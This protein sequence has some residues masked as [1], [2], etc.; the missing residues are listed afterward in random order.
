MRAIDKTAAYHQKYDLRFL[1]KIMASKEGTI[2]GTLGDFFYGPKVREMFNDVL[3][4]PVMV[5]NRIIEQGKTVQTPA[6][7]DFKGAS[8]TFRGVP[9]VFVSNR[10]MN[11][12]IKALVEEAVHI[13]QGKTGEMEVQK[14]TDWNAPDWYEK[15][16]RLPQEVAA[17][18]AFNEALELKEEEKVNFDDPSTWKYDTRKGYEKSAQ[19]KLKKPW[20]MTEEEFQSG[21]MYPEEATNL[22]RSIRMGIPE[23]KWKGGYEDYKELQVP[24]KM[25]TV[26]V[27]LSIFRP[28]TIEWLRDST[29][30]DRID[31]YVPLKIGTPVVLRMTTK[32]TPSVS[33]GGH[34][35]LAALERGDEYIN[36]LVDVGLYKFLVDHANERGLI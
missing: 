18:K 16:K 15:Y 5:L 32:G 30:K 2:V 24:N 7:L 4:T 31:R 25:T 6:D 14:F 35:I 1:D 19:S 8:G 21:T 9:T 11:G 28:D 13:L 34:R 20:E 23:S 33:D 3:G 12:L 26:Q 36:A 10:Q 22:I 17:E 29:D 27:P